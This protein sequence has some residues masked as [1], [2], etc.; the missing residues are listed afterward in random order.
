MGLGGYQRTNLAGL[1]CGL[2]TQCG[3]QGL[4]DLLDPSTWG[5]SDWLVV[6]SAAWIGWK[7][8]SAGSRKQ[9][10]RRIVRRLSE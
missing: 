1:G 10:S 7:V 8:F 3:C 9:L 5:P 2:D 6:A 4:G